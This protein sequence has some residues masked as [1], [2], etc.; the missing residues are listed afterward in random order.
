MQTDN[1]VYCVRKYEEQRN[2]ELVVNRFGV[3]NLRQKELQRLGVYLGETVKGKSVP[4]A[5][6]TLKAECKT[7]WDLDRTYLG[8]RI[9]VPPPPPPGTK[10]KSYKSSGAYR[11]YK[12][13]TVK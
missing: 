6:P 2:S 9:T 8:G 3:D 7:A 10:A 5:H 11:V 12:S 1:A 4:C 13:T